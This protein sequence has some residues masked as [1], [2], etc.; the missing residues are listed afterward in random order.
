MHSLVWLGR[1]FLI[2]L[3]PQPEPHQLP[4]PLFRI[5]LEQEVLPDPRPRLQ[6]PLC[7]ALRI[8]LNGEITS[9]AK[10]GGLPSSQNLYTPRLPRPPGGFDHRDIPRG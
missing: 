6:H 9:N 2:G 7:T 1:Q 5:H 8:L 4:P 10:S 3:A